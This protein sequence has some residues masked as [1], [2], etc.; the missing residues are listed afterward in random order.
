MGTK[1][2]PNTASEKNHYLYAVFDHFSKHIVTVA[3]PKLN[4][5]Y[6]VNSS[7]NHLISKFVHLNTWL[8]KEELNNLTLK[9]RNAVL[10][11]LLNKLLQTP[12]KT[13]KKKTFF[14]TTNIHRFHVLLFKI[15][16]PQLNDQTNSD[17]IINTQPIQLL[18]QKHAPDTFNEQNNFHVENSWK[19]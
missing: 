8:H 17:S 5:L 3:I 10:R 12:K 14:K 18:N 4:A 6:A 13:T 7:I 9:R 11:V 16:S 2:P 19:K 1:V 15:S